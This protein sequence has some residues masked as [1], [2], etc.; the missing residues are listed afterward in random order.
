MENGFSYTRE[1]F[2]NHFRNNFRL[3]CKHT[4]PRPLKQLHLARYQ[5]SFRQFRRSL[6]QV[7]LSGDIRTFLA[8]SKSLIQTEENSSGR[9]F[10]K[11]PPTSKAV[12]VWR[13]LS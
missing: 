12:L 13:S 6:H 2:R 5:S 10:Q 1:S 3:E 11:L 8:T 9:N 4:G 7:I